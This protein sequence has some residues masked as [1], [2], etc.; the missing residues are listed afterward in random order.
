MIWV[1]FIFLAVI[2]GLPIYNRTA[3]AIARKTM[4]IDFTQ[5]L[6]F[7]DAGQVWISIWDG[8][9]AHDLDSSKV[10]IFLKSITS[11]KDS[12]GEPK[13]LSNEYSFAPCNKDSGLKIPES[14]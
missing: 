7:K 8:I 5:E 3:P 13:E 4:A 1:A 2:Q 6:S 12:N 11:F 9:K 10:N 14:Y